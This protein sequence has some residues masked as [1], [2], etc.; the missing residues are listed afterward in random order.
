[1]SIR[2]LATWLLVLA[3]PVALS[4]HKSE[5]EAVVKTYTA[6]LSPGHQVVG[7]ATCPPGRILQTDG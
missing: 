1:M 2:P 6:A 4:A 3:M 7:T 5:Q